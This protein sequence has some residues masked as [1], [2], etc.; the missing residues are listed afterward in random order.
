MQHV[1]VYS[2]SSGLLFIE[3]GDGNR[4]VLASGYSGHG[5]YINDPE[6]E[7][8]VGRG[9]IPR[10]VWRV[11]GAIQHP[12]L[13]PVVFSL[14]PV[15]HD[16]YYRSEFFIH[17]DNSRGDRSASTGCIVVGRPAREVIRALKISTLE[18]IL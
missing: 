9:P 16:A 14:S 17:G 6:A 15:G 12:R 4:A 13:G 2:Q 18:V 3:D 1:L 8:R 10:G 5:E 7:E 11:G